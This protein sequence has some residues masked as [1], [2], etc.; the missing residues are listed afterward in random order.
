MFCRINDSY[1]RI[2]GQ[3]VEEATNRIFKVGDKF[4]LSDLKDLCRRF[5]LEWNFVSSRDC[6]RKDLVT[7]LVV[8]YIM[9]LLVS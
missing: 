5:G 2:K 4:I 9:I 8:K 7:I 3:S 6:K 1:V